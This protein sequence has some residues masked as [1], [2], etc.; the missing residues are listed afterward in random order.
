MLDGRAKTRIKRKKNKVI[1]RNIKNGKQYLVEPVLN[2]EM[3]DNDFDDIAQ[4]CNQQEIYSELFEDM[5]EGKPYTKENAKGFINW[6]KDGWN[7]NEFYIFLIRDEA[8]K[9]VGC[10]DI[11]QNNKIESEIGFWLNKNHSGVM[12]NVVFEIINFG[13][14][15]GFQKFYA[16]A[17]VGNEKSYNVLTRTGFKY[18]KIINDYRRYEL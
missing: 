4:N 17:R 18:S 10:I 13:R 1:V 8:K 15:N 11:K 16:D 3:Q 6:A 14:L 9:I 12:S 5:L 2:A 7:N